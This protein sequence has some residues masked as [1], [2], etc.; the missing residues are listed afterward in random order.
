MKKFLGLETELK[1]YDFV[2]IGAGPAGLA[3]AIAAARR[4]VKTALITNRPVLGGNASSEIGINI[5]GACYNALYSP[6]VYARETG[7]VEE[8]KQQIYDYEGFEDCKGAG[9]DA[10]LFDLVY[11]EKNIDLYLNTHAFEVEKDEDEIRAV[12]CMQLNSER[13]YEFHAPLF[14]ES[15]GDGLIGALAG[16]DFM[17]GTEAK[18]EYGESLGAQERKDIT[19]GSTIM[20]HTVDTGKP[21]PYKRPAFAYDVTKL[22]FFE[23]LGGKHRTFYKGKDGLFH[24]FWWVEFGGHLDTIKDDEEI[25]LELRKIV[26][27][28]WDYIKNSGKFEG[29][30]NWKLTKVCPIA[31]KRESRR[32]YGDVVVTQNDVADKTEFVDAVYAGGWPMDV[33]ADRGIYDNEVATHW[34]FVDGMYNLPYRSLYSRNVKNLFITGRLTSCTR[35]ANGSTRVMSTC[36]AS[37]QAAG[38]AAALCVKYGVLPAQINEHIAELKYELLKD[39]QTLMGGKEEYEIE[40]VAVT[41]SATAKTVNLPVNAYLPL[42]K[43]RVMAIP[44]L[45]EMGKIRFFVKSENVAT[46]RVRV[47]Q[48]GRK[49]NYQPQK[50]LDSFEFMIG[51]GEGE[52]VLPSNYPTLDGKIYYLFEKMDG[53]EL[54]ASKEELTGAPCFTVWEREKTENDP[55]IFVLTRT[56]ENIA[57]DCEMPSDIY[58]RRMC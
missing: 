37:G 7:I 34:H 57:F 48:G 14:A 17:R 5:N 52:I 18:E 12:R 46:L 13:V 35:V 21:Q 29:A 47:L 36:A 8:I 2:V 22:P 58:R 40:N 26:Y 45:S 10:A 24:G 6:T 9:L 25:T 19:A 11:H 30:E 42:T 27:G 32:F 41:S 4:G 3:T 56:R 53:V 50:T 16:A 38:T 31:G 33:H 39:D 15:S 51:K 55:R 49:E 1:N 54:R 20:F 28:L 23:G 44:S 43:S